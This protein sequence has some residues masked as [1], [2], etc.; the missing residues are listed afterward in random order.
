MHTNGYQ[1]V[2]A[3]P[4]R[5][6]YL[7]GNQSLIEKLKD[8]NVLFQLNMLSLSGYYSE[9]VKKMARYLLNEDVI[10]LIGTDCHNLHQADVIGKSLNTRGIRLL[11]GKEFLNATLL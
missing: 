7:Q 10:D 1:P 11:E 2:L 6:D 5:Y 8:M 9:A 4:E 3:H